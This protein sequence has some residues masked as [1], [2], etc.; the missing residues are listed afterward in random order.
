MEMAV[1]LTL[2]ILSAVVYLALDAQRIATAL[3]PSLTRAKVAYYLWI[4]ERVFW[5]SH[6]CRSCRPEHERRRAAKDD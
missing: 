4:A 2:S 1:S 5:R 3:R 6:L